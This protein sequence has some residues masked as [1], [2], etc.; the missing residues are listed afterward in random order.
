MTMNPQECPWSIK[1]V[2][3][4]L[5]YTVALCAAFIFWTLTVLAVAAAVWLRG[6]GD[7]FDMARHAMRG[8]PDSVVILVFYAS[9]YL[10][11]R[12]CI[13]DRYNLDIRRVFFFSPEPLREIRAGVKAYLVFAAVMIGA[14]FLIYIITGLA[15]EIL[16]SRVTEG[17]DVFFIAGNLEQME[18]K[19]LAASAA[20]VVFILL[21]GP[22]FEEVVFRGCL[23]RAMRRRFSFW[24]AA[25]LSSL[26]FAGMH[27]YLFLFLYV[28]ILS[29][30]LTVLYERRGNLLAPL[31]FHVVNNALVLLIFFLSFKR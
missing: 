2:F 18:L 4:S 13:F 27:G 25:L 31:T 22:F 16:G 1:D 8:I 28:L 24:P 15:D 12:R 11:I 29:L 6:A 23:Y 10:A 19:P 9:L 20:G 14:L 26:V 7:S 30:S 17:V 5:L 3:A 21:L